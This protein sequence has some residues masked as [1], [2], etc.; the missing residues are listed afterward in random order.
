MELRS[1]LASLYAEE[2]AADPENA[3]LREHASAVAVEGQVSAFRWYRPLIADRARILDWGCQHGPDSVLIRATHERPVEIVG[4]DF[5]YLPAYP[6]FRAASGMRFDGLGDLVSLPYADAE[7]DAVIAAGVLE[8]TASDLA[9]LR[10]LHRVL[11][12]RGLLVIT[13]LPN[14]YSQ[15]EWAERRSGG[16]HDR[17]YTRR[18][19]RRLLMHSGFRPVTPVCYQTPAWRRHVRRVIDDPTLED[20]VVGALRA[21]LPVHVVRASTLCVVAERVSVFA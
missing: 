12:D 20:R 6:S 7:F 10:E 16:G 2:L 13:F 11:G 14:Q 19:V 3:Y 21:A 9:S 18:L 15:G 5:P 4:A 1:I 8:H 17:L